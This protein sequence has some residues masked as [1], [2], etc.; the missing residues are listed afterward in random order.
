MEIFALSNASTHTVSN[1]FASALH[2]C[3]TREES[4]TK[5]I[6]WYNSNAQFPEDKQANSARYLHE[7]FIPICLFN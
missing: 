1:A 5:R 4:P 2:N 7:M 6:V 3:F